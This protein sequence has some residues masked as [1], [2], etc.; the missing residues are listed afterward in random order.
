[1]VWGLL[2]ALSVNVRAPV[3]NP[4]AVGVNVTS[5]L[6]CVS[7]L[8]PLVQELFEIAKSPLIEMLGAVSSELPMLLRATSRVGLA[9]P[10]KTGPKFSAVG[11]TLPYGT[12]LRTATEPA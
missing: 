12:W 7:G 8:T 6:Q 10:N 1:M 5:T 2:G 3:S 9:S 11:D 4:R